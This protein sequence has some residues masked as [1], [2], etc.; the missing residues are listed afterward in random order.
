MNN[1]ENKNA[2]Q[3]YEAQDNNDFERV[4]LLL[5][6]GADPNARDGDGCSILWD[7]Q[8]LW[9]EEPDVKLRYEIAKLF[10]E[11][12]ADPNIIDDNETLY[13]YVLFALLEDSY[14]NA[15]EYRRSFFKLLVIYGGGGVGY[16]KPEFYVDID[17][18]KVDD[19]EVILNTAEDGYHIELYLIDKAGE[20]VAQI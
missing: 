6:G 8:Y 10:F 7:L 14:S 2:Q 17:K 20:I 3:L 9:D 12:G 5:D 19:Y 4:R 13:D 15:W 18:T 11:H 16:P 1:W